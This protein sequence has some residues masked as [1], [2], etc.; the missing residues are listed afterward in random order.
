MSCETTE[1]EKK[2]HANLKQFYVILTQ[3]LSF[4]QFLLA[5]QDVEHPQDSWKLQDV[6]GPE[7]SE[8]C[9]TE[10]HEN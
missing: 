6:Q 9:G 3:G 2:S 7:E 8:A 5:G 4:H 10:H 1:E